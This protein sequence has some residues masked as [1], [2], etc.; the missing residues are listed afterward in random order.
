MEKTTATTDK[1]QMSDVALARSYVADIGGRGKV[2]AILN[3]AY[4]RLADMFPHRG[5]PGHQWTERRVRAFWYGEAA[6]VEFREM[7]ELHTAAAKAKEE[8]ELLQKARKEH[9]AFIEKTASYRAL[10]ERTDEDFYR[11]EIEGLGG[12]MGGLDRSRV[13][14][15]E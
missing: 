6:Y 10:L 8:R 12:R 13:G 1:K 14:R 5:E 15:G 7:K 9:A 3:A 11:P 4:D 2:K